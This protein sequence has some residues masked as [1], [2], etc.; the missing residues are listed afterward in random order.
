M[1]K[2]L[3]YA[4][5]ASRVLIVAVCVPALLVSLVLWPRSRFYIDHFEIAVD[6]KP[7]RENWGTHAPG[8]VWYT[9]NAI[10]IYSGFRILSWTGPGE[11]TISGS[12]IAK[13]W[14]FSSQKTPSEALWM[15]DIGRYRGGYPSVDGTFHLTAPY[16]LTTVIALAGLAFALP[17]ATFS[18]FSRRIG[19][20]SLLFAMF[21]VA[22]LISLY[23]LAGDGG[24]ILGGEAIA[25]L[26]IARRA[27]VVGVRSD[28]WT[29]RGAYAV[30]IHC[31]L[32]VEMVVAYT[33][34][35]MCG[36]SWSLP[37]YPVM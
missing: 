5:A 37:D 20:R 28:G 10:H 16:R 9:A 19:I 11:I 30:A 3:R 35:V 26:W 31:L 14:S 2:I 36:T 32:G 17:K 18:L 7:P 8:A 29:Q 27:W 13:P 1:A 15:P 33:L 34:Y 25:L 24:V 21:G 4:I 6:D 22:L 23:K 12:Q